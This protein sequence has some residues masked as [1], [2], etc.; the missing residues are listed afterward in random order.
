MEEEGGRRARWKEIAST[1][2]MMTG[3][4]AVTGVALNLLE[5]KT[6]ARASRASFSLGGVS[7]RSSEGGRKGGGEVSDK[8]KDVNKGE[9]GTNLQLSACSKTTQ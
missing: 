3:S 1:D 5:M 2:L 6:S 8:Q 4:R 7:E 9:L